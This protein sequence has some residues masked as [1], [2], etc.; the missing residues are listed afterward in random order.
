MLTVEGTDATSSVKHGA[1]GMYSCQCDTD[2]RG[3]I[4]DVTVDGSRGTHS[5]VNRDISTAQMLLGG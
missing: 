2:S 3:F 5:E 1:T 4:N